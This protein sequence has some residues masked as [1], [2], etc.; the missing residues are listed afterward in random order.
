[1]KRIFTDKFPLLSLEGI[2][3]KQDG[4]KNCIG[5][6]VVK[7][8]NPFF[9]NPNSKNENKNGILGTKK[10]LRQNIKICCL[11][12]ACIFNQCCFYMHASLRKHALKNIGEMKLQG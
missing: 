5:G 8:K 7:Y 4:R 10:N 3:Q 9:P 1:M 6:G 11:P 12:S 2:Q